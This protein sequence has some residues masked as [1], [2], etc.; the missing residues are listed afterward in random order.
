MLSPRSDA[1]SRRAIRVLFV[2]LPLLIACGDRSATGLPADGASTTSRVSTPAP[3]FVTEPTPMAVPTYDGSGQAVHPDIVAFDS[4]WHGARYW[5]TM[6]PYPKSNQT[7][8]NPS[9]LTSNDGLTIDV[10]AGLT[11]PV[12]KPP[13]SSKDY[14]SDPELL[15]EPQTDRLVLFHRFVQKRANT[16]HVS[17]SRDGITWTRSPAPFWEHS[18][19]AVSPTVAVRTGDAARMWYVNAGKAG[20]SAKSTRVVMRTATDPSGR[21]TDTKWAGP[22]PTDLTIPGYIIW[23]IKA[24]WIPSKSEYWML[25]SAFRENGNGCHTDDLFFAR[26]ADGTHWTSYAEPVIRHED[27]EWTATAVY[28]SSFLYDAESDQLSLWLSARGSDGAWRMGYA[29]AHYS[30]LLSMLEA[31][32]RISPRP[33]SA[34][35]ASA[36]RDG[37]QP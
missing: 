25:I 7:L 29:R 14:N 17:T 30:S 12:I 23:H 33:V 8:E 4:D 34:F 2:A 16:I 19:Q 31:G 37:E 18:H 36:M 6:T 1:G 11:N 10:P 3:V 26:S 35:S 9:I 27:R 15:Y 5:L 20:C 28:R 24:R 21:I 32:Q 13:K 22:V